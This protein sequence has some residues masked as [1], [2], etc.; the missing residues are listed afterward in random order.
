MWVLCC[1]DSRNCLHWARFS[2]KHACFIFLASEKHARTEHVWV[3]YSTNPYHCSTAVAKVARK[4]LANELN[5]SRNKQP[6]QSCHPIEYTSS[7][8][9]TAKVVWSS[10]FVNN[11]TV[12]KKNSEGT[13]LGWCPCFAPEG[14]DCLFSGP[15]IFSAIKLTTTDKLES[16]VSSLAQWIHSVR[17]VDHSHCVSVGLPTLL[18]RVSVI[19]TLRESLFLSA[20][21]LR[22]V[23]G[24]DFHS[25]L[26]A[27]LNPPGRSAWQTGRGRCWWEK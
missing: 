13:I 5:R 27:F 7:R 26:L 23:S 1:K 16:T 15:W 25:G 21:W 20:D 18:H 12:K 8:G 11:I 22:P 2:W 4:S 19:Y 14:S 6:M 24:P 17:L 9:Y 3:V 10:G